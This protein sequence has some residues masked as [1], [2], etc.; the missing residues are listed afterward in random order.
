LAV[1]LTVAVIAMMNFMEIDA[2]NGFGAW[3]IDALEV[4]V[5]ASMVTVLL[6]ALLYRKEF[7]TVLKRAKK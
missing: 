1:L 7:G 6:F 2:S 3:I 4:F 5:A